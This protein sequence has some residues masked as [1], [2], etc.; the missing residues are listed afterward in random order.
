[1]ESLF[2]NEIRII[3]NTHFWNEY[4]INALKRAPYHNREF[5]GGDAAP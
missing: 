5:K 1:M 4:K 3:D 2:D